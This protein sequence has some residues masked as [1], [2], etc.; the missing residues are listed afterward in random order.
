MEK[1]ISPAN[2]TSSK[3][4]RATNLRSRTTFSRVSQVDVVKDLVLYL[5]RQ[6]ISLHKRPSQINFVSDRGRTLLREI[7]SSSVH[8]WDNCRGCGTLCRMK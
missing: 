5:L 7:L 1:T 2:T 4:V 3:C 8:T 6:E